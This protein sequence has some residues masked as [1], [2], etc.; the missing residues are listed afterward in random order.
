MEYDVFAI[1]C[2]GSSHISKETKCQDAVYS[3]KEPD[4]ISA[5]AADGHGSIQYF[6]SNRGSE[7]AARIACEKMSEFLKSSDFMQCSENDTEKMIIRLAESIVTEWKRTVRADLLSMPFTESEMKCVPEKYKKIYVPFSETQ[8]S[9][10]TVYELEDKLRPEES[11]LYSA[12]GTTLIVLGMC[13]EY[14]IGLHIGDGKCV[15]LYNDGSM[16]EP[17]PWD[18][19]CH[20][21]KCTSICDDNS[22]SE[23]RHFVWRDKMPAAVFAAS[24]GLDDSFA[25]KLHSFYLN[26]SVDFT[27]NEFVSQVKKLEDTLPL[28]SEKGSKDDIS[29]VGIINYRQ[30]FK[31]KEILLANLKKMTKK[32]HLDSLRENIRTLKFKYSN[33][34]K[35]LQKCSE[36]YS[37][38]KNKYTQ[39]LNE[40]QTE[41]ENTE[42]QINKLSCS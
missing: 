25:D 38:K 7:F 41:I 42:E 22:I 9:V 16:D 18:E 36:E 30:L 10:Y 28:I 37:E 34:E 2:T 26:T 39:T 4:C 29:I 33:T 32:K 21:N 27:E 11:G 8:S 12:Y 23:F 20:L 35:L 15:A 24:D 19:R 6:R 17:I 1:K 13:S 3:I 14:G 31:I 40:L 5:A